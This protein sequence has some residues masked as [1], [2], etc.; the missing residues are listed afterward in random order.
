MKERVMVEEDNTQP[1]IWNKDIAENELGS[2]PE[3]SPRKVLLTRKGF[4]PWVYAAWAA[5]PLTFVAL[6]IYSTTS[7]PDQW[8]FHFA[9][10]ARTGSLR[11]PLLVCVLSRF[12]LA[13][14]VYGIPIGNPEKRML[15]DILAYQPHTIKEAGQTFLAL[16][17]IVLTLAV[18]YLGQ[19][20]IFVE[21]YGILTK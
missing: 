5:A 3:L 2:S 6:L 21:V 12:T 16:F 4:K 11:I 14:I 18:L 1:A 19:L 13:R 10:W 20:L 9:T 7:L 15:P 8:G 17:V